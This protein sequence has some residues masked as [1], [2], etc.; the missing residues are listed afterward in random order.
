MTTAHLHDIDALLDAAAVLNRGL[1]LATVSNILHAIETESENFSGDS[2][3]DTWSFSE[4]VGLIS[5]NTWP[6]AVTANA[7]NK[8]FQLAAAQA[9]QNP[10]PDAWSYGAALALVGSRTWP[11]TSSEAALIDALGH[12]R[13]SPAPT[14][15]LWRKRLDQEAWNSDDGRWR[16]TQT[17]AGYELS[18]AL[19]ATFDPPVFATLPGPVDAFDVAALLTDTIDSKGFDALRDLVTYWQ[20]AYDAQHLSLKDARAEADD[21]GSR[22]T[23]TANDMRHRAAYAKKLADSGMDPEWAEKYKTL[24]GIF[25][26]CATILDPGNTTVT[27]PNGCLCVNIAALGGLYVYDPQCQVHADITTQNTGP[28]E[29]YP[30]YKTTIVIWSDYNPAGYS[31]QELGRD[32]DGGGS[33]ATIDLRGPANPDIDPSFAGAEDFFEYTPKV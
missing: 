11:T 19:L 15:L 20:N 18:L 12:T 14:Q 21:A 27:A 13:S 25:E 9:S 33:I 8:A 31:I 2:D 32:A 23:A 26:T 22:I 4:A 29:S 30:F 5:R 1:S 16:V 28:K 3:C 24:S 17:D 10:D 7:I 6:S